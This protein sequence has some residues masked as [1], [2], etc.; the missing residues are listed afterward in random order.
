MKGH[1]GR[2]VHIESVQDLDGRLASGLRVLDGYRLHGLDLTGH[3]GML[4]ALDVSGATFLGCR[5]APGDAARAEE[6]G[7]LVLP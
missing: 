7:A 5:F 2:I 4:A 6:Q 1:R 3:S